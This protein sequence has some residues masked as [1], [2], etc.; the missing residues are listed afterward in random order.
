ME[1]LDQ[2]IQ[3]A[4]HAALA[5]DVGTGDVTARLIPEAAQG[6]A[7]VI[8]R[9]DAVLCGAAWFN[10][11][12]QCLDERVQV[13]WEARDGDA[14][15]PDR[16]LCRLE[17]PAR[18]LLTGERS[19]LNFLQTLSGTATLARRYAEAVA[20]LPVRILDTRKTLPGLRMAQK[21]AVRTGG[22]HN[23]R[24]GL[25]DGIL[26]KENHIA[27]SG[28]LTA[29]VQAAR[30]LGTGLAVEVEVETLDQVREALDAGADI[31]L[32]DNFSLPDLEAAVALTA[33]RAK[34]EASGGVNLETV[35][36]IAITGVDFISV[37]SLTKDVRALDL[38][39]RFT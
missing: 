29:A 35:R 9:E 20:G 15:A 37:G 7:H 8:S 27:A 32:L 10:A 11:V 4:V 25:Y 23:H 16:V 2:Q 30:A 31:L 3:Q 5:E 36:R 26:I 18:A 12:F 14:V 19:A 39:M 34:L 28:N 13:H 1:A 22:C 38:S 21:Y 33:G 24:S 6:R 17:G